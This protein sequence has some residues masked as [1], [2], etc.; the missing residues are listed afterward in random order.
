MRS[1]LTA[2]QAKFVREYLVDLNGAQA[3]IRAGYSQKGANV[4]AAE[5]L[6]HRTV[7]ELISAGQQKRAAK[8]DLD[9]ERVLREWLEI[10]TADVRELVQYVRTACPECWPDVQQDEP[11]PECRKCQGRGKGHVRVADT[12]TLSP[13]AAKLY[14]GVQVGRDGI[15]V[16]LRDRDAAWVNI[17]RHLGMFNDKLE[18]KGTV[19]VADARERLRALLARKRA[20]TGA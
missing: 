9:A 3:A 1:K 16:N 10:A 20:A 15:K 17:A 19:E 18:L 13:A 8:L 6:A 4:R 2:R 5:L 14:S 12:R 7:L 11:N